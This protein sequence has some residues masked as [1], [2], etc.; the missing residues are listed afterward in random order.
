MAMDMLAGAPNPALQQMGKTADEQIKGT[1]KGSEV[2]Y[3]LFRING[4][5]RGHGEPIGVK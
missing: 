5:M 1:P 2:T 3:A 4:G